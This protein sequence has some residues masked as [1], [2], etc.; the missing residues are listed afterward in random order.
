MRFGFIEQN[1]PSYLLDKT[2]HEVIAEGIPAH[3][4]VD[5]LWKVDVALNTFEAPQNIV[6]RPIR[7]LS[8]GWQRLALIA[9]SGISNPDV[10]L[11]DEPTNHLDLE[12]I[13]FLEKWLNEQIKGIPTICVSHDRRF[14]DNCTNKT[15]FVRSALSTCYNYPYSSAR[16]ILEQD[17]KSANAQRE[18]ELKEVNRL[19]S[20]AHELRQ[21]GVNKHSDAALKRSAQI[22]RRAETIKSQATE[23]YVEEK[24]EVRLTNSGTHAKYMVQLENVDISTPDGKRLF[25]IEE[26][27]IGQNDRLIL[28]GVNGAGKTQ[29]V[30]MLRRSFIDKDAAKKNGVSIG[31]SIQLG[32]IDQQLSQLPLN[33]KLRDFIAEQNK[34]LTTHK[35][36]ATLVEA[37]FPYQTQD[38][39][40]KA[41]SYG[42]RSRLG[43]LALKLAE[44]N[45]Y[46]MDEPTNHLDVSG[47]EQLEREILSHGTS[48]VLVSHDRSFVANL[49]TRFCVIHEG[50]LREIS[51][52]DVFYDF[53]L[54]GT[55]M[56]ASGNGKK[57]NAALRREPK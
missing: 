51:S 1:I 39:K 26:L 16:E 15:L 28:L 47:Q 20:R 37:G 54:N 41:L 40:I 56:F 42:E 3:D 52:P 8:G 18:R 32:Y 2:L 6:S 49:G 11:L 44:P 43:L 53:M 5:S 25:H 4:R 13:F 48:C 10:L 38:K 22:A 35:T 34:T 55:P 19:E 31:P 33:K 23:V 21:I 14:L 24:R 57:K 45:F 36:T 29:F 12:K 9:R 7:E 46:I 50:K 30:Q 17:D 27:S